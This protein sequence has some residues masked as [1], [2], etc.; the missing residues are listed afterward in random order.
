MAQKHS[1]KMYGLLLLRAAA[2]DIRD[3]DVSVLA[4]VTV[5]NVA[6]QRRTFKCNVKCKSSFAE[7]RLMRCEQ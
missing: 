2:V 7:K 6:R 4:K 1:S 3:Y 5:L